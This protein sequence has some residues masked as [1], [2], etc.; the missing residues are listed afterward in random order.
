MDATVRD[1][2][3]SCG[4]TS[5]TYAEG[6]HDFTVNQS[7]APKL[8]VHMQGNFSSRKPIVLGAVKRCQR[9]DTL[10]IQEPL[11]VEHLLSVP[12]KK[13]VQKA[14]NN[15]SSDVSQQAI[16]STR[17]QTCSARSSESGSGVRMNSQMEDDDSL[18]SSGSIRVD[19]NQIKE[20]VALF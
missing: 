13:R 16:L 11:L 20:Q 8:G 4:G 14:S 18:D 19:L 12:Q 3:V 7:K 15:S 6:K 9:L 2:E 1:R 17:E 5:R 10:Q